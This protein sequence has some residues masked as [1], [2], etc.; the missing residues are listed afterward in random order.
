MTVLALVWLPMLVAGQGSGED[1]LLQYVFPDE[2][3]ATYLAGWRAAWGDSLAWARPDYDDSAWAQVSGAGLWVSEGMPGKGVRWYRKSIF[4]PEMLDSLPTLGLYQRAAVAASEVYWDGV[5]IARNGTVAGSAAAEKAGRSGQVVLVPGGLSG[6]GRHLIALRVSNH[7]T[8][9]GVLA[10]APQIGRYEDLLRYL[11]RQAAVLVFLA[12]VFLFAGVFHLAVLFGY[13]DRW[14]YAIFSVFCLAC[15]LHILIQTTLQYFQMD[16]AHYYL[17]V[18]LNDLPW[19]LMMAL[20]PVFF[21]FEYSFPRTWVLSGVIA[22]VALVVVGLPWLVT[23][24]LMPVRWL[25]GFSAANRIHSYATVL[26]AAGVSAWAAWQRKPG[27]L[28]SSAGLLAFL[29]GV[30]I[31]YRLGLEY[32]WAAGFAILIVFLTISLSRQMA[33]RHRDLQ[34]T[35]LRAAR[36]ELDLL[37]KHIQPHFLLNS[38]NSIIAWLEEDPSTAAVLVQALA[39]ELRLLLRFAAEKTVAV[40][41]ELRLCELHLK[42]MG[43]RHGKRFTLQ[44]ECDSETGRIPP[45]TLHTLTENGL[46]HGY[47]GR[48]QGVFVARCRQSGEVMRLEFYNDSRVEPNV[49]PGPEGTGLRYVQSRLEEAYPGRWSLNSGPV[50]GGW[51]VNIEVRGRAE[52]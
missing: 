25:E 50:A 26:L 20:L 29:V 18:A 23:A 22:G 52:E 30:F 32:G 49:T 16:L 12:G 31:T 15:A 27:S 41:E 36:L 28:V 37:K 48:D 42:V 43:L 13:R 7:T 44:R 45:L 3:P 5:L 4:I 40:A 47:A 34:E 6:P 17:F 35:Q 39:D 51:Q 1:D 38:L 2:Q 24:G 14:P 9:S 10:A 11:F 33:R 21:L 8:Y 46:T 19:F